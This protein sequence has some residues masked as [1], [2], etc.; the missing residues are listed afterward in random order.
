MI[1]RNFFA[2]LLMSPVII[3]ALA[4]LGWFI[5]YATGAFLA[6]LAV[7]MFMWGWELLESTPRK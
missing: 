3:M 5:F 6:F 7:G 2:I 4:I 1:L